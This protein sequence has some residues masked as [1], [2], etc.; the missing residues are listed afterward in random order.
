MTANSTGDR[1]G[2][3]WPEFTH[4]GIG[5]LMAETQQDH[6]YILKIRIE[7][8]WLS[9]TDIAILLGR[10]VEPARHGAGIDVAGVRCDQGAGRGS[11]HDARGIEQVG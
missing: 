8:H 11:R 9:G 4:D 7:P 6:K 2:G 5:S 3:L 1:V 10:G